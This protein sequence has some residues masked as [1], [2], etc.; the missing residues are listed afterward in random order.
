MKICLIY[1]RTAVIN[2]EN[3]KT[4]TDV[5]IKQIVACKKYAHWLEYKVLDIF[6]DIGV[7]GNSIKRKRLSKLRSYCQKSPPEAVIVY[8]I[9]RLAR[10]L[11]IFIQLRKEFADKGIKLFSV[12]EGDLSGNNLRGNIIASIIEWESEIT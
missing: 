4:G 8:G 7:S 6:S 3:G 2:Q 9:D 1:V 11:S 10:K 5:I 12:N